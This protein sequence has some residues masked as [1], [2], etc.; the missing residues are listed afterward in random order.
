[1][2]KLEIWK[3]VPNYDNYEVS[4]LGRVKSNYRNKILKPTKGKPYFKV[5]L[6][7]D[8]KQKK[9]CVHQ[10]VAMAFLN[11]NPCGYNIVI[12]HKNFNGYDNR[13]SNLELVTQRENSNKKHLKSSSKYTG[14]SWYKKY[15]KWMAYIYINGKLKNLGYYD[16][17]EEAKEIYLQ[18]LK[19]I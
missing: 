3:T 10:L 17:E 19:T 6:Y 5:G 18:T 15:K 16:N 11:H 2:S 4:N 14:V 8:K 12:N 13:L 9:F 7:K 1:M